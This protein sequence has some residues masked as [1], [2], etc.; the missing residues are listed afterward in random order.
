MPARDGD[1]S[2]WTETPAGQQ[3]DDT[4]AL[5][6]KPASTLSLARCTALRTLA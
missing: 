3:Q 2:L 5:L 4:I 1:S 6:D